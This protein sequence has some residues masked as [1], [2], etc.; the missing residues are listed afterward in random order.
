MN[1]LRTLT[2]FGL[3]F[4]AAGQ[5]VVESDNVQ[6][7]GH[8]QR[9]LQ[10]FREQREGRVVFLG[11]SI[12]EMQ[13]YRPLVET[14]LRETFPETKFTFVNAGI[15]ST[16]SHTGAFRFQRDVVQDG[17]ADLLF[18]EFA[19]NDD[20][21]AHHDADGCIRGMEGILRQ[22]F[23]SNSAAGAVMVHFVNPELLAAAQAGKPGLSVR[24]HERVARHYNVSSVDLTAD[25]AAAI[26]AGTLSWEQ[27][28]GTHPGP[29]GNR[30]AADQV[31]QILSA[32]MNS[33]D[34]DQ[35]VSLPAPLLKSSFDGGRFLE[36][37][38]VKP[39]QGWSRAVPDWSSIDGSKRERFL[40]Q[41]LYFSS[42]PGSELSCRFSGRAIGAFVLAGPDAGRLE[43][44]I[45]DGPWQT[46]ELYHHYSRGL[47]YPRTVMFSS[48]LEPGEHRL[49]VRV[50]AGHHADS[51]GTAARILDFVVNE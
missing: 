29:A 40:K 49:E 11:G 50:S 22:L 8:L 46:V 41:D 27:W 10:K 44:R 3:L 19:V 30:H 42:L 48:D 18:V 13:G 16:C 21:D 32:A 33:T 34:S 28:G 7:R 36:A 14:W 24:Q 25:L 35:D 12:T 38:A 45:D 6:L 31:I 15:A 51:R 9:A 47:H 5:P 26:A 43:Y 20:Q 4:L 17:P 39:G 2:V 37:A 1:W 23:T